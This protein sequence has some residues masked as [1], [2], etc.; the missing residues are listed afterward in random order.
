MATDNNDRAWKR[1]AMSL[2]QALPGEWTIGRPGNNCVL[3]RDPV[4]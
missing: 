1:L 3:I 4:D 2:A